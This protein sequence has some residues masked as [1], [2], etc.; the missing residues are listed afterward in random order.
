MPSQQQHPACRTD[1]R[2]R[3]GLEPRSMPPSGV[4]ATCSWHLRRDNSRLGVWPRLE[5]GTTPRAALDKTST[6]TDAAMI[7]IT[8]DER[9]RFDWA[10]DRW[11]SGLTTHM[12]FLR[13]RQLQALYRPC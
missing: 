1:I 13:D 3:P 10:G 11:Q 4:F 2:C 5:A 9:I 12:I 6:T 8:Q 7:G